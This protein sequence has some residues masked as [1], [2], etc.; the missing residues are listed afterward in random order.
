[1]N[2]CNIWF[3]KSYYPL[4]NRITASPIRLCWWTP[5]DDHYDLWLLL[6][7]PQKTKE[8]DNLICVS[9][10]IYYLVFTTFQSFLNRGVDRWGG[11]LTNQPTTCNILRVMRT[12]E[13]KGWGSE[14]RRSHYNHILY[15]EFYSYPPTLYYYYCILHRRGWERILCVSI[16]YLINNPSFGHSKLHCRWETKVA[17]LF[18][19]EIII[20]M[21]IIYTYGHEYE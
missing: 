11:H 16:N 17:L 5:D 2:G 4:R 6:L 3:F 14:E 10:T 21:I 7:S 20:S 15:V 18:F 9:C 13:G 12:A 19:I 8:K 1:M